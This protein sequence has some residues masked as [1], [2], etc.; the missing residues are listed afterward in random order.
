[1]LY[2]YMYHIVTYD[3]H[4]QVEPFLTQ[5]FICQYTFWHR[6]IHLLFEMVPIIDT[7][8]KTKMSSYYPKT[9]SGMF[10]G[11]VE[12]GVECHGKYGSQPDVVDTPRIP[13]AVLK[14][15]TRTRRMNFRQKFR[16]AGNMGKY[17]KVVNAVTITDFP[18]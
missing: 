10:L 18:H 1:M 8:G 15:Q 4:R 2:I 13:V 12:N 17:W 9:S 11:S 6:Y 16:Y 7:W 3:P 5:I 14:P